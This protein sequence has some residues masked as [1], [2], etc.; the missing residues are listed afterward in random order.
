MVGRVGL[1]PTCFN[2]TDLQ[3]AAVAAVP[4]AD[5]SEWCESNTR[6]S[7]PKTDGFPL[8]YTPIFNGGPNGT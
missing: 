7:V 6:Y 3:S 8:A 5:M 4:S 2:V 1:E